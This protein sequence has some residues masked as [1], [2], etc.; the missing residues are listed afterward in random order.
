MSQHEEIRLA[1]IEA[2]Y[3][4]LAEA[5]SV[6][7]VKDIR[8]KA[9]AIRL[10]CKQQESSLDAQNEAA[11]LKLHAE[12]RLGQLLSEISSQQ[13]KPTSDQADQKLV[14]IQELG[15][16]YAHSR[17]WQQEA[18]LAEDRFAAYI[19]ETKAAGK[20]LTTTGVL[21]LVKEARQATHLDA[22]RSAESHT[23]GTSDINE[24]IR[25]G[26]TFGTIYADPPWHYGNQA[27]R[28]STNNHYTTLSPEQIARDFAPQIRAL[29]APNAHLHLWTTNAFLFDSK[30]ILEAWGFQYKSIFIWVKPQMGMGNYWRLAHELLLFG[31]KG[32][33]PFADRS[34]KS[35][36]ETPRGE[37]SDKPDEIRR[38]IEK[39]SPPAYFELFGR[40]PVHN[41]V[42][43]GNQIDKN[44]FYQS[45]DDS[46]VPQG[47]AAELRLVQ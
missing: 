35:W 36:L 5:T 43:Y 26:L 24:L 28:A 32:N 15:I 8:D 42:V 25:R 10:Y 37:H 27:T 30:A 6:P 3:Q 39:V 31:M 40:R 4:A 20:E 13:G 7:Q 23:C 38:L 22:I 12:R 33:C 17:R 9:E 41:W 29:S 21:H 18:S 44:L 34:I 2:G 11:E 19:A 45:V 46:S 14:R 47:H 1:R 16:S